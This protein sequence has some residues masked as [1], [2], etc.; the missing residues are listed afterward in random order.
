MK[1]ISIFTILLIFVSA[2][3]VF[4]QTYTLADPD[5]KLPDSQKVLIEKSTKIEN[6]IV[7]S[8]ENIITITQKKEQ[9]N[10]NN[11]NIKRY[12]LQIKEWEGINTDLKAEIDIIR[13]ELGLDPNS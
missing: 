1:K 2:S 6:G 10:C 11:M 9:I 13:I 3:L 7:L 5:S 12:L 4:G 8:V